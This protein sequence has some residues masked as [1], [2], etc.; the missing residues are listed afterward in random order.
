MKRPKVSHT[1]HVDIRDG[2]TA[3][4]ARLP[5]SWPQLRDFKLEQSMA[6]STGTSILNNFHGYQ[7]SPSDDDVPRD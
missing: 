7:H 1:L 5:Q 6:V 4:E 2:E 3:D